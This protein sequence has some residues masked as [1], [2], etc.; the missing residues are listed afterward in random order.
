L[1]LFIRTVCLKDQEPIVV[2]TAMM[3]TAA[4]IGLPL[5]ILFENPAQITL[6]TESLL[7]LIV[8]G[9]FTAGIGYLLLFWLI[10]DRGPTFASIVRFNEPPIAILLAAMFTNGDLQ[11][12][13]LVGMAFILLCVAIMNGYLDRFST[14]KA[15]KDIHH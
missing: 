12:S 11:L 1:L 9:I 10:K 15:T 7:A 6:T 2:A 3:I 5:T 8:L 14:P 13:M 4:V